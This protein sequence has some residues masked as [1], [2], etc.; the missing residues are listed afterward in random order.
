MDGNPVGP[1]GGREL[2]KMIASDGN[3]RMI[4]LEH[5]NFEMPDDGPIP[6]DINEPNGFYKLDLRKS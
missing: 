3:M 6:F 2:L 1:K 5:C 4:S